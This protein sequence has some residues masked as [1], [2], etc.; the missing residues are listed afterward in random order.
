[1]A[2]PTLDAIAAE[3]GN[4][5]FSAWSRQFDGDIVEAFRR[6]DLPYAFIIVAALAP[7][8]PEELREDIAHAMSE[9]IGVAPPGATRERPWEA[10]QPSGLFVESGELERKL[11]RFRARIPIERLGRAG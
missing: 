2:R 5:A 10:R 9:L 7:H 1:M 6:A 3:L 8:A 11:E 4:D